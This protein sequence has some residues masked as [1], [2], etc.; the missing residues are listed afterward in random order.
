MIPLRSP[1]L[2]GGGR[3]R[4]GDLLVWYGVAS[5]LFLIL[6]FLILPPRR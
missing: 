2:P 5:A 6:W 1:G 4:V 3:R